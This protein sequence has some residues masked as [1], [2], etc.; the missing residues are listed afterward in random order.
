MNTTRKAIAFIMVLAMIFCYAPPT[1]F[2]VQG[3]EGAPDYVDMP[4]EG[5]WSTAALESAVSNGLLKGVKATDGTYIKPNDT[6]TRAQMAT[7]VNRA[8]GA[9]ERAT[10]NGVADVSSNAWYYSDMGKA[11]KMGTMKIDTKMRPNDPVTRQEAFTVLARAIKATGGN[12]SD[13]SQFYDGNNLSSWAL[14]GVGALVRQGYVNGSDGKLTPKAEI[15]RAQFAVIMNNVIKQYIGTPN[16]VTDV[17]AQG[18]VMINVPGTTL[19]DLTINGD[20]IIGDG[21]G[22]GNVTLDNVRVT[23]DIIARGGGIDSIIIKGGNVE[24]KIVISKV[25]GKIRVFLEGGAEAEVIVI[26]DGKDDVII[27]GNVGTLEVNASDV[28]II[29]RN[30][31]IK[32]IEIKAGASNTQIGVEKGASVTNITVKGEGTK[33]SGEGEVKTTKIEGNNTTVNTQNT[34]VTVNAGVKDT[35]LNGETQENTEES[36]EKTTGEEEPV[37]AA[38]GG[39][40]GAPGP[41]PAPAILV[42]E[43]TVTASATTITT[44]DG[45][46]QMSHSVSPSAATNKNVTWSVTNIDDSVTNKATINPTTGLLKAVGN[47]TVKVVATANDG[48]GVFGSQIITISNQV[49]TVISIKAIA[50]VTAPVRGETP[51]TVIPETDQYTG[52]VTWAPVN[53]PFAASTI[54]TAIIQLTAKAGFTL[55]GV[56]LNF[57][58]VAGATNVINAE[59]T[60]IVTAVFLATEAA[61][62]GELGGTVSIAGAL[63]FGEVLTADV[64]AITGNT[65]AFTYTWKRGETTVGANQATYTTLEADIGQTITCEVTSSVETGTITGT[66][67]AAI[68]KADG[69]IAPVVVGVANDAANEILVVGGEEKITVT[70]GANMTANYESSINGTDW[71]DLSAGDITGLTSAI[72]QIQIRI[73]ETTTSEVGALAT[74]AV[75]VTNAIGD[76]S[77]FDL[78]VMPSSPTIEGIMFPLEITSAA[79]ANGSLL[80]GPN[81]VEVICNQPYLGTDGEIFINGEDGNLISFSANVDFTSGGGMLPIFISSPGTFSLTVSVAGITNNKSIEVDIA[82]S[83][84]DITYEVPVIYLGSTTPAYITVTSITDASGTNRD[85]DFKADDGTNF[86]L[87]MFFEPS[88]EFV[89]NAATK[90][91]TSMVIEIPNP[92]LLTTP[93]AYII[94]IDMEDGNWWDIPIEVTTTGIEGGDPIALYENPERTTRGSIF[95]LGDM[96]YVSIIDPN[97]SGSTGS[98]IDYYASSSGQGITFT[99][100]F[101]EDHECYVDSFMVS[102]SP[103]AVN[104]ENN[105]QVAPDEIFAVSFG[106]DFVTGQAITPALSPADKL[107][108]DIE[109]TSNSGITLTEDVTGDVTAIRSGAGPFTINFGEYLLDGSL[110]LTA[111]SATAITLTAIS[112]GG[113]SISGNLTV[114]A[115]NATVNNYINVGGTVSITNVSDHSWNEKAE[116][117]RI[118]LN[119]SDGAKITIDGSPE[120]LV[121][122]SGADKI[123]IDANKAV[124]IRVD[125]GAKVDK[126]TANCEAGTKITNKGQLDEIVANKDIVIDDLS[127]EQTTGIAISTEVGTTEAA[128]NFAYYS[129]KWKHVPLVCGM[130]GAG[131]IKVSINPKSPLKVNGTATVTCT[132]KDDNPIDGCEIESLTAR[133]EASGTQITGKRPG[134]AVITAKVMEGSKILSLGSIHITVVAA[135]DG[136]GGEEPGGEEQL[137]ENHFAITRDETVVSRAI[138]SMPRSAEAGEVIT[139]DINHI[140]TGYEF[141]SIEV[142][143]KAG[144]KACDTN[145]VKEGERYTFTMPGQE[146]VLRITYKEGST[147]YKLELS[148]YHGYILNVFDHENIEEGAQVKVTV[149]IPTGKA[150]EAFTANGENKISEL[151]EGIQYSFA[152]PATNVAIDVTYKLL[153]TTGIVY[154]IGLA[155]AQNYTTTVSILPPTGRG[156]ETVVVCISNIEGK[157]LESISVVNSSGSAIN[158]LIARES[159][160]SFIEYAFKMP[161]DSVNIT[162]GFGDVTEEAI[163][164]SDFQVALVPD[165]DIVSGERFD[166]RITGARDTKNNALSGTFAVKVLTDVNNEIMAP[167]N[168]VHEGLMEF[169]SGV[170]VISQITL[171]TVTSHSLT[172]TITETS[173][174]CIVNVIETKANIGLEESDISKASDGAITITTL[175]DS[176]GI[177]V[178]QEFYSTVGSDGLY[179]YDLVKTDEGTTPQSVTFTKVANSYDLVISNISTLDLGGYELM[180]LYKQSG[181]YQP[182]WHT[183]ITITD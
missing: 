9:V 8:F 118:E 37:I 125:P 146:V 49:D 164:C 35:T 102:S 155:D 22:D 99:A 31:S 157:E 58:T 36:Y 122:K 117:N 174:T 115:A 131:K 114:S 126:I 63:K 100:I 112:G 168:V 48:S 95:E 25:D 158:T 56:G 76:Q 177:N 180:I 57:F 66:A 42:N 1:A 83:L 51:V 105:L 110:D 4:K 90:S 147:K 40:G 111:A 106:E 69:P 62:I 103:S 170:G 179:K 87:G 20:L 141:D 16:T 137:P 136:E 71:A 109:N 104:G 79:L 123:K 156:G 15:T 81:L 151:V 47:G 153:E 116:G 7:I 121:V 5:F 43:I 84:A 169:T 32:E 6:L 55:S 23:G 65:G 108:E 107:K 29:V 21:V 160:G 64:S 59:N 175:V 142:N 41:G 34:L 78:M 182:M 13:I 173:R 140:N 67:S 152:M 149:K 91:A 60:G 178:L 132:D 159:E 130:H 134:I 154:E 18:N 144:Q 82:E 72:T 162:L 33:I 101:S 88:D 28:P 138:E 135:G 94:T 89:A 143:N 85:A 165:E 27:E 120:F 10:L 96:V 53:D 92:S 73:K 167:E 145:T 129:E 39:G 19:K 17:V 183:S 74:Q 45:T 161:A 181:V 3:M 44:D 61:P 93:G 163:K 12:S 166:L 150:I 68:A 171:E 54:Y 14:D 176:K 128:V 24:G 124:D 50:G 80:E 75:T 139:V 172:V 97:W 30:G 46:L 148:D 86:E 127:T 70:I 38:G 113:L 26:D 98:S 2:A 11:V 77:G 119:D 133:V 52:T